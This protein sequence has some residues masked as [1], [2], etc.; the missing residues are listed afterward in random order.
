MDGPAPT[1]VGWPAVRAADAATVAALQVAPKQAFGLRLEGLP[2]SEAFAVETAVAYR[3]VS[4]GLDPRPTAAVAFP[5][6]GR[7]PR[8]GPTVVVTAGG[9][10]RAASARLVRSHL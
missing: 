7:P 9:P 6:F 3:L 4:H 10:G 1:L 5:T 8:D 2:M